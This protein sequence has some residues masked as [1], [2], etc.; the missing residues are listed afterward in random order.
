METHYIMNEVVNDNSIRRFVANFTQN[1]LNRALNS[2][3]TINETKH[4]EM[5]KLHDNT[6]YVEELH[7]GTFLSTVMQPKKV[8]VKKN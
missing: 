8:N 4:G 6:V 7:T 5:E 1:I 2:T 3:C